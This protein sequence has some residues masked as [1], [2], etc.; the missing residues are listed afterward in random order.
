MLPVPKTAACQKDRQVS[1]VMN[2]CVAHI[3]AK[4]YHRTA[5]QTSISNGLAAQVLNQLQPE[6]K[7]AFWIHHKLVATRTGRQMNILI[8]SIS[9]ILMF[10]QRTES[11]SVFLP[12]P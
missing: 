3:T 2:V 9:R 8:Y 12:I 1:I 10:F 5:E 11:V 6:S 7:Y 4:Q